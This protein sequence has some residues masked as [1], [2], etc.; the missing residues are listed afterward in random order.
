MLLQARYQNGSSSDIL[1]GFQKEDEFIDKIRTYI[2]ENIATPN[3]T[4]EVI[5]YQFGMSRM[6]L[7]RKLKALIQSTPAEYIRSIRLETGMQLLQTK[8]LNIFGSW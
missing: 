6:Q 4:S 1:K 5:S 8:E 7:H 3:L 2:I